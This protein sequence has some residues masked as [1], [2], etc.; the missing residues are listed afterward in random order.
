MTNR[1]GVND[2]VY[3]NGR[4]GTVVSVAGDILTIKLSKTGYIGKYERSKVC[5]K[6][7]RCNKCK[8]RL[9][10]VTEDNLCPVCRK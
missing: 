9:V 1:L 7:A 5:R 10:V 8:R 4:V 6:Y 3:V 2:E